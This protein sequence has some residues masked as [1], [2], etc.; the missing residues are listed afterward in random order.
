ML[1]AFTSV[2]LL[3]QFHIY[4]ILIDQLMKCRLDK[5]KVRWID[6]TKQSG[7]AGI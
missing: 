6:I 5:C 7:V 3:T 1:F 4:I 2:I